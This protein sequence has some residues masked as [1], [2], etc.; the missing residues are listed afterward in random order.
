MGGVGEDIGVQSVNLRAC[1]ETITMPLSGQP[2]VMGGLLVGCDIFPEMPVLFL[3]C[4]GIGNDLVVAS[5]GEF[6]GFAV[7]VFVERGSVIVYFCP[8]HGGDVMTGEIIEHGLPPIYY[9]LSVYNMN[10]NLSS[11][12]ILAREF[13]GCTNVKH[14]EM[15]ATNKSGVSRRCRLETTVGLEQTVADTTCHHNTRID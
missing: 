11:G 14:P 1:P 2:K 12:N 9:L 15:V 13:S 5:V 8:E 7:V 3:K 4:F 10:L 6:T